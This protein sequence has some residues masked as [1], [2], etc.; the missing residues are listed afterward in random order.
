[1]DEL[2]KRAKKQRAELHDFMGDGAAD[3]EWFDNVDHM[4]FAYYILHSFQTARA[5]Q[6]QVQSKA[7]VQFKMISNWVRDI[8]MQLEEKFLSRA[9]VNDQVD[10]ILKHY[11][12]K[13]D[14]VAKLN[15]HDTTMKMH[16]E[17]VR[18]SCQ[19][20]TNCSPEEVK[21][22][23]DTLFKIF[24][25]GIQSFIFVPP[26]D[27]EPEE[28]Q[29]VER[30]WKTGL[31]Q[32]LKEEIGQRAS[33]ANEVTKK[34][35]EIK[36]IERALQ[37]LKDSYA[38]KSV[39]EAREEQ[40]KEAQ[41]D[42]EKLKGESENQ[43]QEKEYI[44]TMLGALTVHFS[45]MVRKLVFQDEMLEM[46]DRVDFWEKQFT[47]EVRPFVSNVDQMIEKALQPRRAL[48]DSGGVPIGEKRQSLISQFTILPDPLPL[49]D[50]SGTPA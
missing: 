25:E 16:R 13:Y 42:L 49:P 27:A 3:G 48:S 24:P 31:R 36:R 10:L 30:R 1:L 37:D 40:L 34:R 47:E 28:V 11:A 18:Q 14:E 4:N 9:D 29:R 50:A 5:A 22:G 33:N 15:D 7:V 35:A 41:E 32:Q 26:L 44:F 19:D 12:A 45:T 23:V 2:L 21:E 46:K 8:K 38:K 43:G 17:I 20:N 39:I 6:K